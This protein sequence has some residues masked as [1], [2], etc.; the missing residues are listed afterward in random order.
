MVK[1][2]CFHTDLVK[3][4]FMGGECYA[5]SLDLVRYVSTSP[6]VRNLIHGAEDKLVARWM[7]LHPE[8]ESILWV[9]DACF[10]YDHPKAGTVYSH[11]FLYPSTVQRIRE[12]FL[13]LGQSGTA[14]KDNADGYYGGS[15]VNRSASSLAYSS[16][17][18]FGKRYQP[19]LPN[20]TPQQQVEALVEG[21]EMSLLSPY[22]SDP[23]TSP[24]RPET[25][26]NR[27]PSIDQ[28]YLGDWDTGRW[29]RGT[30][31]VHYVKKK[32]WFM[33]TV[34]AFM[35]SPGGTGAVNVR[36]ESAP[37]TR[38]ELVRTGRPG[39]LGKSGL[40]QLDEDRE[41][42]GD[43]PVEHESM[44]VEP[45][46]DEVVVEADGSVEVENLADSTV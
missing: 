25:V 13:S 32:E 22:S 34:M 17:S 18:N 11:G 21:S 30:V 45:I 12:E 37:S 10:L 15:A 46:L 5:L 31:V 36:A 8:K 2:H 23:F 9:S 24:L 16:V 33:E 19:P 44:V 39:A 7:H 20:L 26:M 35:G 29:G 42:V 4:R 1:F 28:R 38:L 41:V 14:E 40:W 27:R 3:N 6:A 43:Q